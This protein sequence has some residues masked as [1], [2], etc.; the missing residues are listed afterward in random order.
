V[1]GLQLDLSRGLDPVNLAGEI[2]MTPDQ[3]QA[4]VLRSRDPRLLLNCCRQSGKTTVAAICSLH[5]A[6]YR[7]N[8][9][10]LVLSASERQ[11]RELFRTA[12][13]GYRVLGRP[14]SSE[15]ENRLSL[16]L[17]NGSR[18]VVV[19]AQAGTVR[20]Y[21]AVTLLVVDEAA[22]VPDE[23]YM[24]VRPMLAVSGGR[25]VAM[26]TPYGRRGWWWEAWRSDEPWERYLVPASQCPRITS[27]FLDEERRTVGEW[28]FS[29]EYECEFM[30]AQS[31]AFRETDIQAM[32]SEGIEAWNF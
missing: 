16:E 11:A 7:A 26:S 14:V 19:P 32:F 3:W 20:G 17:E 31:A 15:A 8:A 30:D 28:W 18:I 13:V 1:T 5:E 6:L 25:V 9:L 23:L 24:T 21:A 10:V 12:L 29:Q 22:Q 27:E 4:D 2:G